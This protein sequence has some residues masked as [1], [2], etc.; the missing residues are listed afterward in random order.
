MAYD[1]FR[2]YRVSNTLRDIAS[3][4]LRQMRDEIA[5]S[6]E[7]LKGPLPDTFLGRKTQEPFPK[8]EEE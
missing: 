8:E 5:R 1:P 7:L 6:R 2:V 4:H 3:E